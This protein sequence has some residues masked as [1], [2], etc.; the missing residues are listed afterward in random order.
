MS[1]QFHTNLTRFFQPQLSRYLFL[2]SRNYKIRTSAH[3]GKRGIFI[4][5]IFI[6]VT[7][8]KNRTTSK[9]KLTKKSE[10]GKEM[11]VKQNKTDSTECKN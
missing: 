3:M 5:F 4:F 7:S 10:V 11:N 6:T 1:F 2:S 8:V 9:L